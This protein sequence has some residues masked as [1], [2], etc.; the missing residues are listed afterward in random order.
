MLPRSFARR[1]SLG[2]IAANCLTL[3]PSYISP[4]TI[5]ALSSNFLWV[6]AKSLRVLAGA[7]TSSYPN[8]IE[9][10]PSR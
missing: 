10:A 9:T 8:A 6:F 3:S 1:T 4:A 2:G 7:V 5:P